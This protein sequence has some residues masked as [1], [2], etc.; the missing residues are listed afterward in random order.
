MMK[1]YIPYRV[2][3]DGTSWFQP[4]FLTSEMSAVADRIFIVCGSRCSGKTTLVN[5]LM[6]LHVGIGMLPIHVTRCRR[7]NESLEMTKIL[8]PA[9]FD[10]MFYSQSF[11]YARIRDNYSTGYAIDDF[12]TSIETQ[13]RTAIIFRTTGALLFASY[14]PQV[15]I[16][17]V[18]CDRASQ[19][20]FRQYRESESGERISLEEIRREEQ[21][22]ITLQHRLSSCEYL[23]VYT[24][25]IG[26][27][28]SE[29]LA[30]ILSFI[31]CR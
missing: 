21:R 7:S 27:P 5:R 22:L 31:L 29:D 19:G 6:S 17:F 2:Q 13:D 10:L 14:L 25:H 30:D 23:K 20:T 15:P 12:Y 18:E 1:R 4:S 9:Q 3:I 11:F 24:N 16:V 28:K 26:S 8:S